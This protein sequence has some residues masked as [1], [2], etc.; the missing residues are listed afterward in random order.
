MSIRVAPSTSVY[1]ILCMQY[2][3][4]YLL[5]GYVIRRDNVEMKRVKC[6]WSASCRAVLYTKQAHINIIVKLKVKQSN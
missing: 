4:K 3:Y 6:V 5:R 1:L 2:A